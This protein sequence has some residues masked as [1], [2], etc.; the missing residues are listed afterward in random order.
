[1]SKP[2]IVGI[3]VGTTTGLAIYDLDKNLL[4]TGSKKYFSVSNVIKEIMNF[5][6]PLVVATDKKAVS[7]KIKK[8]SATFNCKI[9]SPDHDLTIEEKE[10]ILRINIKDAHER[11]ALS[12][13]LFA[14]REYES[15][16]TNINRALSTMNLNQYRDKVKEMVVTGQ[17]KNIADA[18]N[19]I[20]P[21]EEPKVR[22]EF[23]EI[24]LDWK[25]KAKEYLKRLRDWERK[26]DISRHYTDKL[27]DKVKTLERQ[28]KIYLEDEMKK[29]EKVRK[30]LLK[31]KELRKMDI[32]IRQLQFEL[33]KQ[34]K[35]REAFEQR[36]KK[37]EEL[38]GIQDEGLI[39]VVRIANFT[40]EDIMNAASEFGI[41]NKVVWIENLKPS[42]TVARVLLKNKPKVVIA[43]MEDKLKYFLKKYGVIVIDGVEPMMREFYGTVSQKDLES[44]MKKVEKRDFLKWL[45]E[46]RKR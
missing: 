22:T 7:K 26:Y 43:D 25:E 18:I 9:Y 14:F 17:A 38:I 37:Q 1:M 8:I 3:D 40:K 35:L 20:R 5:G 30:E 23:K 21:K 24:N 29:N 41:E 11:D 15:L 28:K 32:V 10:S 36:V 46:Y 6:T 33:S 13:A 34:K 19:R 45:E 44:T 42:K 2:L 12:A 27:E 16:F 4:F 39:A 31:E